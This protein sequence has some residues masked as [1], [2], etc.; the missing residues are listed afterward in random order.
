MR[1]AGDLER[2]AVAGPPEHGLPAVRGLRRLADE[3]E[4]RQVAGARAAGWSWDEIARV[5]GRSRQAVHRRYRDLATSDA[6]PRPLGLD[7]VSQ[8]QQQLLE[9]KLLGQID[10]TTFLREFNALWDRLR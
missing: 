4:P 7:E 10:A 6:P 5:L 2:Y 8:R 3:C 9:R 1:E